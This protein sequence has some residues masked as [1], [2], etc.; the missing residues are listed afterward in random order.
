MLLFTVIVAFKPRE[1]IEE[2]LTNSVRE[3]LKELGLSLRDI[4]AILSMAAFLTVYY[5]V[6]KGGM[7]VVVAEEAEYEVLL[8]QPINLKSYFAGKS[9]S[10]IVQ[11]LLYSILY[12][13]VIPIAALFTN[14]VIKA[15]LAPFILGVS[16]AI[17]PLSRLLA[18]VVRVSLADK[19][20]YV[21][22][23][24]DLGISLYV[25]IGLIDTILKWHPSFLLTWIFQP[26]FNAVLYCF[27]SNVS[28]Y[29]VAYWVLLI[30][31]VLAG[32]AVTITLL[33]GS[34]YPE[35]IKPLYNIAKEKLLWSMRPHKRIDLWSKNLE[36]S[37]F[38][39]IIGI[40]LYNAQR[41]LAS[42]V[43]MGLSVVGAYFAKAV[44]L[45][46]SP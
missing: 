45:K 12:I 44:F 11:Y 31:I 38:K 39:Y 7:F 16:L 8:S 6:V 20:V 23:I 21:E 30:V 34:I 37:L 41:V 36:K 43:V 19:K 33:G 24:V 28:I 5:T 3:L 35:R 26:T 22:K 10:I 27:S 29:E 9:L 2:S 17:F 18:D 42:I 1:V 13:T 25:V 4:S 15:V 32:L 14:D 40:E 46:I